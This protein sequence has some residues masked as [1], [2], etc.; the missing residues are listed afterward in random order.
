MTYFY[1]VVKIDLDA[2][3]ARIK[4]VRYSAAEKKFLREVCDLVEN[5]DLNGVSKLFSKMKREGKREW[6]EFVGEDIWHLIWGMSIDDYRPPGR[7]ELEKLWKA[8]DKKG[9]P[10]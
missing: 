6:F 3:R 1:K 5:H 7:A 4:R 2:E 9:L 8:R 10:T